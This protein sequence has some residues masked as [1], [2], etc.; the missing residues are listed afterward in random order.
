M[1]G[2][3]TITATSTAPM[4]GSFLLCFSHLEV[5]CRCFCSGGLE[6]VNTGRLLGQT[7]LTCVFSLATI[8]KHTS[9]QQF[10]ILTELV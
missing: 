10:I 8:C 6:I 4:P 7:I 9:R 2:S 3:I 5:F 1:V